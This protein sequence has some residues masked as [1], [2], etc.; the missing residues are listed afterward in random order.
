[1]RNVSLGNCS[2]E[3]ENSPLKF[4]ASSR[5]ITY[6]LA[7]VCWQDV[8]FRQDCNEKRSIALGKQ[9]NCFRPGLTLLEKL[10]TLPRPSSVSSSPF[11]TLDAFGVSIYWRF[12]FARAVIAAP[13]GSLVLNASSISLVSSVHHTHP[14]PFQQFPLGYLIFSLDLGMMGFTYLVSTQFWLD[15]T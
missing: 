13:T 6:H 8:Q 11:C 15:Y 2:L 12:A 10:I 14:I 3:G 9:Q 4:L 7:N 1:M 5:T